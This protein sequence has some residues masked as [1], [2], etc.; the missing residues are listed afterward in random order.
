MNAETLLNTS[1]NDK[2][3]LSSHPKNVFTSGTVWGIVFTTIAAI[4][5][6]LGNDIDQFRKDPNSV[7]Y[8]QDAAKV[9]VILCGAAATICGR[10]SA[11]DPLYTPEWLPGPNKSDLDPKKID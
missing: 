7:N 1:S 11:K 10:V 3:T 6:I 5:P 4:A 9:I 8:G 2:S